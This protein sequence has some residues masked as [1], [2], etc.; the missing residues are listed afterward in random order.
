[1]ATAGLLVV[2]A[3]LMALFLPARAADS[4]EPAGSMGAE[5]ATA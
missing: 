2:G 5:V 1:M 4:A 3:V